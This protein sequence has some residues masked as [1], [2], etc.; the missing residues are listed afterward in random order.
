MRHTR[1]RSDLP[2]RVSL[3]RSRL[4]ERGQLEKLFD[5]LDVELERHNIAAN[6]GKMVDLTFVENPRGCEAKLRQ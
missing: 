6:A 3:F 5:R 2:S 1:V 4:H